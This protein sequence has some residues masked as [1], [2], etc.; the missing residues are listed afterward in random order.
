MKLAHHFNHA[1]GLPTDFH[2]VG[3]RYPSRY[4]FTPEMG[5]SYALQ[6]R[7]SRTDALLRQ[8]GWYTGLWR[9]PGGHVYVSDAVGRVH[10]N[11]DPMP[12]KAPWR[13]DKLPG[14][15]QGV[16]GVNDN[17]VVVWGHLPNKEVMYRWN[18]STWSEMESPGRV[19]AMHGSTPDFVY[20]V[21]DRGLI[22]RWDGSRW[23]RVPSPTPTALTGVF[24]QGEDEIYAVGPGQKL[25]EGSVHG[26]SEILH[27]DGGML[28]GVAKFKNEV[29]VG[30]GELGLMKLEKN[31]FQ[32]IK[33]NIHA[34]KL[35][36]RSALLIS[37]PNVIAFTDD[38]KKFTGLGTDGFIKISARDSP[39]WE[40]DEEAGDAPDEEI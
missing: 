13:F 12:R 14:L 27:F 29:W 1:S 20:A 17:F 32:C 15:L 37:A 2:F 11:T 16:W 26:W 18:G 28:Y 8:R 25:L 31:K 35:E 4:G 3:Y 24:V 23:H 10:V 34:E 22:A 38:G 36:V 33:P 30:A 9:S 6:F 21:G 39:L 19:Y 7:D 40:E 5:E